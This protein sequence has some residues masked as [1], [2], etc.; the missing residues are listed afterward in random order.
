MWPTIIFL[1]NNLVL[2][3]LHLAAKRRKQLIW[4]TVWI[5]LKGIIS[6]EKSQTWETDYWM[7]TFIRKP[8]NWKTIWT[9]REG[10]FCEGQKGFFGG[11]GKFY[12]WIVLVVTL[13][14]AFVKTHWIIHLKWEYFIVCTFNLHKVDWFKNLKIQIYM[15]IL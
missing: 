14:Y 6:S 12:I 3:K 11:D 2:S 13:V 7:T 1:E 4:K 5:N 15:L 10:L 8:W 9:V